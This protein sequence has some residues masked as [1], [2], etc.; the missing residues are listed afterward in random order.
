MTP[1]Q[2]QCLRQVGGELVINDHVEVASELGVGVHLGQG[3]EDPQKARDLLGPSVLIGQSVDCLESAERAHQLP[4]DYIAASPLFCSVH[5]PEAPP[6]TLEGFG[7][8][9]RCSSLPVLGIGGIT[10]GNAGEIFGMGAGIAVI[11]AIC[12]AADPEEVARRLWNLYRFPSTQH[13]LNHQRLLVRI[14]N[15]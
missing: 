9:I 2:L 11:G 13:R 8:L 12:D 3:D 5:K 4:V 7:H 1:E 6:W 14:I 10:S 15:I